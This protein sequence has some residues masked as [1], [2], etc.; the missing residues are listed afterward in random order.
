MAIYNENCEE[1]IIENVHIQ[2]AG[3]SLV[4]DN[5]ES[6]PSAVLVNANNKGYARV[7]LDTDS[8]NFLRS[9]LKHI[10]NDLNRSNIWRI[11]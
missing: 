2:P 8:M 11:L 7:I 4:V 5:L 1:R 3:L 10:K 6:K 9:N